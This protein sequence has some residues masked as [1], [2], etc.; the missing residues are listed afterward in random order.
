MET[1]GQRDI[2]REKK[3]GIEETDVRQREKK[4]EEVTERKRVRQ[5]MERVRERER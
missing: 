4:K 5:I 1:E 2:H 3:G